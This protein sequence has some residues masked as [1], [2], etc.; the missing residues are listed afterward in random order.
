M[1]S[2]HPT[3]E[4]VPATLEDLIAGYQKTQVLCVAAKL[5]LGG[6]PQNEKRL[7]LVEEALRSGAITRAELR[8]G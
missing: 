3:A 2:P 7:R 4:Q 1:T 5:G 8:D 6:L